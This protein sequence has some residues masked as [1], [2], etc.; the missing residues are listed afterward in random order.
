MMINRKVF[1]IGSIKTATT[2]AGHALEQLGLNHYHGG[3]KTANIMMPMVLSGEYEKIFDIIDQYD[4]FDDIPFSH[5]DFY[6]VLFERYPESKFVLTVRDKIS[7][8]QSMIKQFTWYNSPLDA[9]L[10]KSH[11]LDWIGAYKH[12]ELTY[13]DVIISTNREYVMDIYEKRNKEIISFFEN[14]LGK[15]LVLDIPKNS[16]ENNWKLL[17]NFLKKPIPPFLFPHLNKKKTK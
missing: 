12:F 5:G 14:K 9:P 2:T 6:K 10:D 16:S 17:C 1:I 8:S 11:K 13:G 3:H 15:L 7:W 4:S